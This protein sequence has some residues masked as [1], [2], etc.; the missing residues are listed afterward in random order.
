[1]FTGLIYAVSIKDLDSGSPSQISMTPPK[2]IAKAA[3]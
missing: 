1:M 3:E 2:S